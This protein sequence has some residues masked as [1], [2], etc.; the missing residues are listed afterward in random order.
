MLTQQ[1]IVRGLYQNEDDQ[2]GPLLLPGLSHNGSSAVALPWD[3]VKEE[4]NGDRPFIF[5]SGTHYMIATGFVEEGFTRDLLYWDPLGRNS[6]MS[7]A[8]YRN[9]VGAGGATYYGFRVKP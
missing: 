2:Q 6:R 7:Y 8:A 3:D 5:A 9:M 1:Q 4:I